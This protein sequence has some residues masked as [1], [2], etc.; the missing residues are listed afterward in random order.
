MV[1]LLFHEDFFRCTVESN[2]IQHSSSASTNIIMFSSDCHCRVLFVIAV[3]WTGLQTAIFYE[4]TD[5]TIPW[6]CS[7]FCFIHSIIIHNQLSRATLVKVNVILLDKTV[8]LFYLHSHINNPVVSSFVFLFSI[9]LRLRFPPYRTVH[10][11]VAPSCF[12]NYFYLLIKK[13]FFFPV[14]LGW[15]WN[16]IE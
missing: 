6:S 7:C 1:P 4:R 3:C 12:I 2:V 13:F 14:E 8:T 16:W 15:S 10:S 11:V 5:K 9:T